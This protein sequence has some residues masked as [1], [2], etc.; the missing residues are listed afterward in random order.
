MSFLRPLVA[1]LYYHA[2]RPVRWWQFRSDARQGRVPIAVLVYHRIADDRATPW[3]AGNR[4]FRRQIDWLARHM[5]L[6]S[7]AELQRRLREGNDRPAV[8]VTFDDGYAENCQ[9]AIPLLVKRQ[10]PCTYFVT[11][12]QVV[13]GD[14]FAHDAALGC[15]LPP[16]SVEQLRAMAAAG[17][18]IGSHCEEHLDL[19]KIDDPQVLRRQVA[20]SREAL[21]RRIGRAVRYFAFPFGLYANLRP[22]AFALAREC[23]YEAVCSAYGGYNTPGEEPF[24]VQRIVIDDDL[25]R[26]MNRATI[27]PRKRATP[28]Y[29]YH[30]SCSPCSLP[31]GA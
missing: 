8:H 18:E 30:E 26:L 27:D 11:L 7:M 17:V 29:C 28:R 3:T 16:N 10:I 6:I 2:S 19:A 14:P 13:S 21:A 22:L 12:R 1:G 4:T 15:R 23:G 31:A 24:H 9:E 5:E 20:G 25:P